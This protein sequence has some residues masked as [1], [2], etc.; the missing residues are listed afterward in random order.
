MALSE[1]GDFST[2][3]GIDL[4]KKRGFDIGYN[5]MANQS[6]GIIW[7]LGLSKIGDIPNPRSRKIMRNHQV[8]VSVSDTASDDMDENCDEPEDLGMPDFLQTDMDIEINSY[9]ML[10]SA[11][12]LKGIL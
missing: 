4:G 11:T 1:H 6:Y 3:I 5:G 2:W 10:H 7:D 9:S 12:F 8:L